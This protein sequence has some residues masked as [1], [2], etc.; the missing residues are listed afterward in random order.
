MSFL[1]LSLGHSLFTLHQILLSSYILGRIVL[2][3]WLQG[4]WSL[5]RRMRVSFGSCRSQRK[6][7]SNEL[8]DMVEDQDQENEHSNEKIINEG[9]CS[10]YSG[11]GGEQLDI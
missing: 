5:M 2:D 8:T 9:W 3:T 1:F 4:I 7:Q 11:H 6:S 10:C